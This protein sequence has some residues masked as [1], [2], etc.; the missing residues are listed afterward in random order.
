MSKLFDVKI[1]GIADL[2]EKARILQAVG[3][4]PTAKASYVKAGNVLV[5]Q[6]RRN[7]PYNPRR[8]RGTHL[9]DAIFVG[10]PAQRPSEPNILAGVNHRKAPHSHL[11]EFGTSKWAGKPFWRPAIAQTKG[12]VMAIIK[13][14]LLKAIEEISG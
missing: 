2:H 14:G 3:V 12:E 9:R 5:Q 1:E 4:S 11:V 13:A 10:T 7:A 6:A 8:K